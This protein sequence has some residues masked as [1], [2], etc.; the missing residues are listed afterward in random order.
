MSGSEAQG[1]SPSG[2]MPFVIQLL[3]VLFVGAGAGAVFAKLAFKNPVTSEAA[4][5]SDGAGHASSGHTQHAKPDQEEAAG[6]VVKDIVYPLD[7]IY[8][9]LVGVKG[10]KL[11][12]DSSI[13]FDGGSEV[14]HQAIASQI[15]QDIF[16]YL[17]TLSLDR[18]DD[19]SGLE[20]LR[21]DLS[22]LAQIRS[23]GAAR[24]ILLR[25]LMVE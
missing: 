13:V 10:T 8:V 3:L 20:F 17:R 18:I 9:S 11:R 16:V 21:E 14:D 22:D 7:P 6:T 15:H 5:H 12:L 1:K 24:G 23:G 2:A 4:A 25:G 19:A